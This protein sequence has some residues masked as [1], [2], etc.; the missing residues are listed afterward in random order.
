MIIGRSSRCLFDLRIFIIITCILLIIGTI[1][2]YSSSSVYALEHF[3]SPHYFIKR[4]CI[5]FLVGLCV[6][7]ITQCIPMRMYEKTSG[8]FLA[9]ATALTALT[10]VPG[11]TRHIH[12]SSRWLNLGG[13]IFQPS[14]L[15]K[16][17]IILFT[18]SFLSKTSIK[19]RAFWY[20]YVP[21]VIALVIPCFILLKQPD[22]GLTV[23]LITTTFI[24]L[25]IG[26]LPLH[27]VFFLFATFL[28]AIITLI[29]IKP[30][31]MQRILTFLNP[32][33]DPQGSG[34]QIIQSLIAIG[35]GGI[36]G[37]GIGNSKQKFFYLPMQC[38]DFIFSIIAEETGFLGTFIL[39][40]LYVCFMYFGI[41][42][43]YCTHSTFGFFTTLGFTLILSM[44][45]LINIAV[46]TGL[47]PTKGIGLPF[48]SYGNTALVCNIAMIG[49][50]IRCIRH[51][52][53]T[54]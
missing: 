22:F 14:E 32:W 17:G 42:L 36:T 11:F 4:H 44:Q 52:K 37:L 2:I 10:L 1:F 24:L 20:N 23:T 5:G 16:I 53:T 50:I 12:G 51:N 45:S 48:I 25:F 28:I 43:A 9:G 47:A 6:L 7:L 30:Y 34:F 13:F 49:I 8:I 33:Q 40:A 27:Y 35:S 46:A 19:K 38:T 26:L 41:R 54:I 3:G 15:I 29:V 31:R 21:I 39:I 18:A